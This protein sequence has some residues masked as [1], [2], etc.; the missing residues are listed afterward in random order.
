MRTDNECALDT[1]KII[2]QRK[3]SKY[4]VTIVNKQSNFY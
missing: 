3:P 4:I 2:V 1:E